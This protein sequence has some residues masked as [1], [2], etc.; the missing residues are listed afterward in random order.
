MYVAIIKMVIKAT[1]N[2][3]F[4]FSQIFR[5]FEFFEGRQVFTQNLNENSEEKVNPKTKIEKALVHD[6]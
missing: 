2:I 1:Q 3:Q 4:N 6:R 5:F